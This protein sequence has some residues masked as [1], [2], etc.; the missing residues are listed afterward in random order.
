MSLQAEAFRG[1]ALRLTGTS[2]ALLLLSIL[3][4]SAVNL[5][6]PASS[7]LAWIGDWDA[8][9]ET[10]AFQAGIPVLFLAG[11]RD[12]VN[13][14]V[15]VLFDARP[16]DQYAAGHLPGA[17]NLP[18]NE[19]DQRLAAYASLLMMETPIWVYCGGADCGDALE[20]AVQLRSFGFENLTLYPGG[21]A[22]WTEYGG[23]IH[24]GDEP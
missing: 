10:K 9:I 1:G 3:L 5:L 13:E 19:V 14:N 6:R 16:P 24:T 2:A 23:D 15:D 18:L 20:L 4:G 22:E 12:R 21:F 7:R 8:H 11:A 17:R